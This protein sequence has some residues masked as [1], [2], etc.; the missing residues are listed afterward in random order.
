MTNRKETNRRKTLIVD[1]NFQ[2]PFIAKFFMMV[3]AGSLVMGTIVYFFCTQTVTTLFKDSRLKIIS[4]A[5][6]ILPGLLFSIISVIAVVGLAT[7]FMALYTSHRIAGPVFR[8]RRDLENF[9]SGD[10]KQ[11]F[12]LRDKDEIKPLAAE[13]DKMAR[14]VQK[15]VAAL[16]EEAD[17]LES[18]AGELSPKARAHLAALKKI[19]DSYHA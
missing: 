14:S 4:T 13:L 6:F 18:I 2:N 12:S 5:D 11:V 19:L 15:N 1:R 9:R 10:L 17:A 16:K 7:A 3:A 8:L